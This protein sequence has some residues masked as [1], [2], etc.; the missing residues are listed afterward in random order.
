[1]SGVDAASAFFSAASAAR[2]TSVRKSLAALAVRVSGCVA[3]LQQ[4]LRRRHR[5]RRSRLRAPSAHLERRRRP[6]HGRS[7]RFGVRDW[8]SRPG[9]CRASARACAACD[10]ASRPSRERRARGVAT[11]LGA[12][13]RG[14]SPAGQRG[15]AGSPR[16]RRPRRTTAGTS[17]ARAAPARP[18]AARA[19]APAAAR[20]EHLDAR[21]AQVLGDLLADRRRHRRPGRRSAA[22]PGRSSS[23]SPGS[24]RAANRWVSWE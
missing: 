3:A 6:S 17:A 19:C 20:A 16:A 5:P 7:A 15:D 14:G 12:T 1:M 18:A 22:G 8:R 9:G 10:A 2:S 13:G 21:G 24:S 4:D 11:G 23:R